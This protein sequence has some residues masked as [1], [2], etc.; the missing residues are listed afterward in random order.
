ME[1]ARER[2]IQAGRHA[3]GQTD[4]LWVDVHH[5]S[6]AEEPTNEGR[7]PGEQLEAR[8]EVGRAAH[9]EPEAGHVHGAVSVC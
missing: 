1:R 2:E 9:F 4:H 6:D 5:Q 3:D 7:V 8:P